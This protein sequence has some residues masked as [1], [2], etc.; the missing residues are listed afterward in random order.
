MSL[1]VDVVVVGGGPVGLALSGDLAWRGH[2]VLLLD[3]GDGSIFQ[4]KMDLVGIRTMEFCRRWGIVK[5]VEESEY[6]RNYPQDNVYLTSLNGYELGR[7]KMPSMNE[8]LPP[9]ESPQ[10]RERCPQNYF[11]PILKKFALSHFSNNIYYK[12]ECIGFSQAHNQV[13]IQAKDLNTDEIF[14]IESIFL[15][16][17]DGAKS[18]I[19]DSLG[20]QMTG[21][22]LLTYTT[23]V[24]FECSEFNSLHNKAP[25]YRY[26]FIGPSGTWCTIVAIN[27]KDQWRMSLIGN[28]E[29]KRVY[30]EEEIKSLAYKAVGTTFDMKILSV[31]PWQRAE[32]VADKYRDRNVFICGDSCHLTSPTGG[33]GM[34]TGIG[35][36]VDLSWKLSGYL[37]GWGGEVLLDSYTFERK[38]IAERITQFSTGNLEIMKKLPSNEFI[39]DDS[40]TGEN[41]REQVGKAMTEGLKREWFSLNMHLGNRYINS[42]INIYDEPEDSLKVQSEFEDA[43]NYIPSTR[44]G[45]RAPHIWLDKDLSTLDLINKKYTLFCFTNITDE[46]KVICQYANELKIPLSIFYLDSI[47]TKSIYEWSFVMIRPDGHVAWRGHNYKL[48]PHLFWS[49]LTGNPNAIHH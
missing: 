47:Q 13:N 32:L 25:G 33:L 15:V 19:R 3:K 27:G 26:M 23:N 22:G 24:I 39:Y 49:T 30:T 48:D 7:Q 11:D 18:L 44:P 43:I 38:P 16:G 20:I 46:I 17:C 34:N 29:E 37:Q 31:L 2:K 8:E 6:D 42:P 14:N 41:V 12:T 28:A 1:K 5:D 10:K 35:D 45:A 21:K 36:A 4:P 9:K 40:S